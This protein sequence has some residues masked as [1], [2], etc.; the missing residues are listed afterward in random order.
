[1]ERRV[2][3]RR[4]VWLLLGAVAASPLVELLTKLQLRGLFTTAHGLG[5]VTGALGSGLLVTAIVLGLRSPLLERILGRLDRSRRVH[6]HVGVAAYVLLLVHPL[7]LAASAPSWEASAQ[8]VFGI[9]RWPVASGWLALVLLMFVVCFSFVTRVQHETWMRVHALGWA[10]GAAGLVHG[11]ASRGFRASDVLLAAVLAAA[12]LSKLVSTIRDRER[13]RVTDVQRLGPGIVEL[14]LEPLGRA[15][16][17]RPGQFVL[18]RFR[19]PE[20]G[21]R[22]REYHPFTITSG[23]HDPRLRMTIKE[24]GD[25][26]RTLL[27]LRPGAT[28]DVRGPFG[29]E[30]FASKAPRQVWLAGGIGVTPFLGI[31]RSLEAEAPSIDLFYCTKH[32]VEAVHLRELEGL[33]ARLPSLRVHHHVDDDEGLLTADQVLSQTTGLARCRVLHR[34]TGGVLRRAPPRAHRSSRGRPAHSR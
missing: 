6:H 22:C 10:A 17:F 8:L 21:W 1:M 2:A 7:S 27:R 25:C 19:D 4:L 9:S 3:L 30:L 14:G 23:L 16:S 18:M 5:R 20:T 13:Y 11:A 12:A 29:G 28:A 32:A 15:L 34:R 26:T 24:L 33:A 31:A